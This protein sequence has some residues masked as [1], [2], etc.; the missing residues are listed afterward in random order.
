LSGAKYHALTAATDFF[1]QF[2]IAE[3]SKQLGQALAPRSCTRRL[4]D[5]TGI[6]NPGYSFFIE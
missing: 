5:V 3:L 4:I 1:E 2:V 6:R